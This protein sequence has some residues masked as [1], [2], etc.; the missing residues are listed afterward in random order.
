[1]SYCLTLSGSLSM[2]ILYLPE[3]LSSTLFLAESGY[4]RSYEGSYEGFGSTL[5]TAYLSSWSSLPTA[6][7]SASSPFWG[8]CSIISKGFGLF[9]SD[10]SLSYICGIYRSSTSSFCIPA[11][12]LSTLSFCSRMASIS[13]CSYLSSLLPSS[14]GLF[15]NLKSWSLS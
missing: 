5:P 3:D 2:L 13:Y 6:S 10:T 11:C 14:Y 15:P 7:S 12:R 1:M 4:E 9:T 8:F